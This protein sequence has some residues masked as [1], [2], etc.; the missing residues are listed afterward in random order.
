MNTSKSVYLLLPQFHRHLKNEPAGISYLK[1]YMEKEGFSCEIDTGFLFGASCSDYVNRIKSK[2]PFLVGIS[3]N[4]ESE[5]ESAIA[6]AK[7]IK[8]LQ[9]SSPIVAGGA[10]CNYPV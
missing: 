5:I 8:E 2:N 3:V 4:S 6:L 10:C 7:R 9:I 1:S